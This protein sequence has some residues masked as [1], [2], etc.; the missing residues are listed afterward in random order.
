MPLSEPYSFN[1]F[2][3]LDISTKV[4]INYG[5]LFSSHFYITF[6]SNFFTSNIQKKY[7]IEPDLHPYILEGIAFSSLCA[8]QTCYEELYSTTNPMPFQFPYG[9]SIRYLPS[10]K[11]KVISGNIICTNST[12]SRLLFKSC[13]VCGALSSPRICKSLWNQ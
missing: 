8:L 3:F 10:L 9:Q 6:I 7:K 13:T 4:L 5:S 12:F 2:Y 1:M 11:T